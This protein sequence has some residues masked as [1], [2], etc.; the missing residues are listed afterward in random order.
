MNS[1]FL[2]S[3]YDTHFIFYR[4][5]LISFNFIYF[6]KFS[7]IF[8]FLCVMKS[9]YNLQLYFFFHRFFLIVELLRSFNII[10]L[11]RDNWLEMILYF[12]DYNFKTKIKKFSKVLQITW[13]LHI[14]G[15]GNTKKQNWNQYWQ[16]KNLKNIPPTILNII[17]KQKSNFCQILLFLKIMLRPI[18]NPMII[19]KYLINW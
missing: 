1:F 7:L 8:R 16:N 10:I 4:T 5:I 14:V 19:D 2:I 9:A 13:K 3:Q 11:K 17:K 15:I 12:K 18:Y 6:F